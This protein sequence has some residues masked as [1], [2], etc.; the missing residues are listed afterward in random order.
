MVAVSI[1]ALSI[2]Q[3]LQA[4]KTWLHRVSF[5]VNKHSFEPNLLLLETGFHRQ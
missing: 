1:Q 5:N 2:H 4:K 3:S